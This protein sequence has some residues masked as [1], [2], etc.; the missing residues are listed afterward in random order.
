MTRRTGTRLNFLLTLASASVL[1]LAGGAWLMSRYPWPIFLA[2]FSLARVSTFVGHWP[3]PSLEEDKQERKKLK[4]FPRSEQQRRLGLI[5]RRMDYLTVP[6]FDFFLDPGIQFISPEIPVGVPARSP[7]IWPSL[8]TRP[9]M[10][11]EETQFRDVGYFVLPTSSGAQCIEGVNMSAGEEIRVNLPVARNKRN[12]VFTV[13]PLAPANLRAWLGQFSWAR[14]FT[15]ADVHRPQF[16]SIPVNDPAASMLRLSLGTGQ[17][18]LTSASI[19]QWDRSGRLPIQLGTASSLWRSANEDAAETTDAAGNVGEQMSEEVAPGAA[20]SAEEAQL[21]GGNIPPPGTVATDASSA[22]QGSSGAMNTSANPSTPGGQN[23]PKAADPVKGKEQKG[24]PATTAAGEDLLDPVSVKFNQVLPVEGQK[25]VA[26]GYNLLFMQLDPLF[27]AV[28]ADETL[29]AALAPNLQAFLN[30]SLTFNVSLPEF[31]QG[32]E[33]YQHSIVRQFGDYI[34]V[35]LPIL[36]KDL[37][38]RTSVF[39]LYQEFRNFGYKVVSFA[40]PHALAFPEALSYGSEIPTV[41]GRWLDNN[42]WRFVARRKELDQQNEPASGL[43][44]IFKNERDAKAAAVDDDDFEKMSR[45]LSGL[46]S[47]SDAVPDWRANELSVVSSKS[48]YLPR[49]VDSF[50]RWTKDNAQARFF[51]HVYLQNDDPTV[52]PSFKD[53]LRVFKHRKFKTFATPAQTEKYARIVML[54]RVFG[55]MI[56][57][58]VAR[59]SYHRTV[60]SVLLPPSTKEKG[61]RSPIGQFHV[62]IPGLVGKK[63]SGSKPSTLDD[64]LATMA[65]AVGVQLMRNDAED[66]VI[67]RGESLDSEP[68]AVS[69]KGQKVAAVVGDLSK[70]KKLEKTDSEKTSPASKGALGSGSSSPGLSGESGVTEATGQN[71]SPYPQ[72]V[73]RF[74]MIVLPRAAGCQ[75]FEWTASTPY[76]GLKSSQPIV[77]EPAPRGRVIR[78]F[79]C[80]LRDQVIE[81]TWF[82]SHEA[83]SSSGVNAT[84]AANW[85]G[86]TLNFNLPAGASEPQ[87]AP[88]F[89][90]GPQALSLDAL[91]MRLE[92]FLPA[93]I[94]QLFDLETKKIVESETLAR[95]LNLNSQM[96]SAQLSARTLVYFFREPVR[97]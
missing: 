61:A 41:A 12:I 25:S 55:W 95:L 63:S 46:E 40:P 20:A 37:I 81:L 91:P 49:L 10:G 44:A 47:Q 38:S 4:R 69:D 23:S 79:P 30:H 75:S 11:S 32:S 82:Q 36:T 94:P 22:M 84:K 1:I 48:H 29:L 13:V 34:P 64:G 67:F 14:Q 15:D 90:V 19:S 96:Q 83:P 17:I 85:M 45:L 16:V 66:R 53:F 39:N 50:Q 76:F 26:I 88:F 33:L 60:V 92:S 56:D 3:L 89:L 24:K 31:K 72:Q 9:R 8:P 28:V 35:N 87:D 2:D 52:R 86:G 57:N 5:M 71:V 42:D 59:R 43:E 65:Q 93:E 51:A 80:G 62:A 70:A 68:T 58:L 21:A 78:V 27:N 77:E 7:L 74:R 54:D 18:L 6:L 73:S 97:R